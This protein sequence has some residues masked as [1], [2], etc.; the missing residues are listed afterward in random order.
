MATTSVDGLCNHVVKWNTGMEC[1]QIHMPD[2]MRCFKGETCFKGEFPMV[3]SERL[4]GPGYRGDRE[5]FCFLL[6]NSITV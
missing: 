1:K 3:T 2:M 5:K 4:S 6:Y